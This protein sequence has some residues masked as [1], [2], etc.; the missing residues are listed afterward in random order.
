M[1]P[2]CKRSELVALARRVGAGEIHAEVV[3]H[4]ESDDRQAQIG[5]SARTLMRTTMPMSGSR[6]PIGIAE[7]IE[8]L[9]SDDFGAAVAEAV[10]DIRRSGRQ[11]RVRHCAG[12]DWRSAEWLLVRQVGRVFL[13]HRDQ[14]FGNHFVASRR[15]P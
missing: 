1:S 3:P 7:R 14:V 2:A 9:D 15:S 10:I 11:F 5:L 6:A 4:H 13:G 12:P 8:Y